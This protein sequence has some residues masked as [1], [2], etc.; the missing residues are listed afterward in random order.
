MD[1]K[2]S[3]QM[4]QKVNSTKAAI[5]KANDGQK[6]VRPKALSICATGTICQQIG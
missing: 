1:N 4:D 2:Q 5:D 3:D 6:K